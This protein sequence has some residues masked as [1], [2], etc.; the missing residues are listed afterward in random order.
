[1]PP[2]NSHWNSALLAWI[3]L[4]FRAFR[5]ETRA[6]QSEQLK[7]FRFRH[8]RQQFLASLEA[9]WAAAT[10]TSLLP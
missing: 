8:K 3:A 9:R 5:R 6:A 2:I 1:M 4:D 10:S 7:R